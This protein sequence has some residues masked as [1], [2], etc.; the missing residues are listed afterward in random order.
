MSYLPAL[1]INSCDARCDVVSVGSFVC[2]VSGVCILTDLDK[3]VLKTAGSSRNETKDCD[4]AGRWFG[5]DDSDSDSAPW[6][7]RNKN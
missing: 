6:V 4:H 3:K 7:S 5:I 1:A 2:C